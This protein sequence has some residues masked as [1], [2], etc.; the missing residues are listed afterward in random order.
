MN[1]EALIQQTLNLYSVSASRADWDRVLTTFTP[2]A[3][4][5]VPVFDATFAGLEAIREGLLRFSGPMDYIV[6]VNTP[7]VI[8]VDGDTAT[9]ECV[10]R[11]GGKFSG[12]D[13]G[14]EIL[15][16]YRD[17]L[18]RTAAGWKFVERIFELRG[19]HSYPLAPAN[20]PSS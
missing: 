8:T 10:I 18:A 5:K 4:W 13:E 19:M 9:A 3:V 15:G 17:R 16:L 2:D 6:Q 7:A 11:E 20:P 12:R 1:D 14:L